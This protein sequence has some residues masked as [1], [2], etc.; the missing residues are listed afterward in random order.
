MQSERF[1]PVSGPII[2]G[3]ITFTSWGITLSTIYYSG[4]SLSSLL[5]TALITLIS[6][7][8][9]ARPSCDFSLEVIRIKNPFMSFTI[10]WHELEDIGARYTLTF[11]TR[12]K[13]EV[14]A[15][16]APA[17]GR[18]KS[19]KL[20]RSELMGTT[21]SD[22]ESISFGENPNSNSGTAFIIAHHYWREWS[23]TKNISNHSFHQSFRREALFLQIALTFGALSASALGL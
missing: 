4:F 10:P 18:H 8:V 23:K 21:L 22:R 5:W 9:F 20:H 1:R 16:A 12:N 17:S 14:R 11:T 3:G 19:R 15:W 6:F 13:V 7:E 2:F